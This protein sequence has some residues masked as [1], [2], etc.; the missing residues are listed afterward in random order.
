MVPLNQ[1]TSEDIASALEEH[2]SLEARAQVR[3][4]ATDAPSASL[5]KSLRVVL[6]NLEIVSLDTT[7]LPMVFEYASGRGSANAIRMYMI[8]YYH[9]EVF[10]HRALMSR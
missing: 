3:F 8:K 10:F 5:L 7:H 4:V 2:L 9:S 6:P 1:E